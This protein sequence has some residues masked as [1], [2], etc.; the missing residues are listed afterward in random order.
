MVDG[1][2]GIGRER[3]KENGWW[4][5]AERGREGEEEGVVRCDWRGK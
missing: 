4:I 1:E 3:K 5:E 2:G